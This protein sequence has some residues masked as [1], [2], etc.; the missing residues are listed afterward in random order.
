[1]FSKLITKFIDYRVILSSIFW[2]F[3]FKVLAVFLGIFTNRWLVQNLSPENLSTYFLILSYNSL[4]I[5]SLGFGI[6]PLIQKFYTNKEHEH[7]LPNI[8]ATFNIVRFVTY[9]VAILIILVSYH[10]VSS[11][12]EDQLYFILVLFS[13]Q[14][15]LEID[16]H[17]QGVCNAKGNAWQFSLTDLIGKVLLLIILFSV[18]WIIKDTDL[19]I[20]YV[21]VIFLTNLVSLTVDTIWQRKYTKWGRFDLD[22]LKKNLPTMMFLMMSGMISSVYE[23]I[24]RLIL[25]YFQFSQE[26]IIAYANAYTNLFD[27]SK[28]VVLIAIPTLASFLKKKIDESSFSATN[29]LTKHKNF[30]FS[31]LLVFIIG[32][33]TFTALTIFGPWVLRFI[34]PKGKYDLSFQ[35]LPI[36]AFAL[37]P[38]FLNVFI[39]ILIALKNGEKFNFVIEF[40]SLIFALTLYFILIPQMSLFG[41]AYATLFTYSF[42]LIIRLICY[43]WLYNQ[44]NDPNKYIKNLDNSKQNKISQKAVCA[45]K[46]KK[47]AHFNFGFACNKGDAAIVLSIQDLIKKNLGNHI[48]IDSFPIQHLSSRKYISVFQKIFNKIEKI[49][50]SFLIKIFRIIL[51]P[52]AVVAR[53]KDLRMVQK[54]NKYDLIV[55]G[56]GG[57]YSSKWMLPLKDDI[58]NM[59]KPPVVIFAGGYNQNKNDPEMNEKHL[60][61]IKNLYHKSQLNSVRD[62]NTY[63]LFQKI[64]PKLTPKI[65]PDPAINLFSVPIDIDNITFGSTKLK[66]GVN[67]AYHGWSGQDIYLPKI[68]ESYST[69]LNQIA[70]AKNAEFYYLVHTSFEY[71]YN[72]RKAS[73]FDAVNLLQ[74]KLDQKMIICDYDP[75]K[76]KY[77]YENLDIAICMMLHSSI[78]AFASGIPFVSIG[79][80]KK[81]LA[82]ME[83]IGYPQYYIDVADLS[84]DNLTQKLISLL[85][86][87]ARIKLDFIRQKQ[88]YL[89]DL[90]KFVKGFVDIK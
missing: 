68:I 85:G 75:R 19:F 67:V 76:L 53:L 79:Y 70:E 3:L 84:F 26:V 10:Y 83:F 51:F 4:I 5:Q 56:G 69:V 50:N 33:A 48:Q 16:S 15:L 39:S 11:F 40:V 14:F 78:L 20:F 29:W 7:N 21:W 90:D 54:V 12:Q 32:F 65:L 23:N 38:Y 59:L 41:A 49:G 47:I 46:I 60:A 25:D 6:Y 30:L 52:T 43:F 31:F 81:N 86:Q 37:I 36:L 28:I 82:F 63:R 9:F 62:Y 58:I 22:L 55:I 72:G 61:S 1:M 35:V 73:E 88:V 87:K 27:K 34:D 45:Q 80:D 64:D 18:G 57:I 2:I 8:W 71:K 17:Y 77:I 13:A 24:D 42:G 89:Q 66:V 44:P 74:S